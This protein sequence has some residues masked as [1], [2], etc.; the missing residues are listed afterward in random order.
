M[1]HRDG[2]Q[3]KFNSGHE[4]LTGIEPPEGWVPPVTILLGD[5]NDDGVVNIAD[6]TNLIDYLLSQDATGLNLDA[7]DTTSDGAVNI[8]DVTALI[9]QLLNNNAN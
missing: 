6:V 5:V 7:A 3:L 4:M 2:D 8:A 1:T 9:D